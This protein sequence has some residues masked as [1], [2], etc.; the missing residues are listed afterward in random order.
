MHLSTDAS[1]ELWTRSC[2]PGCRGEAET[3]RNDMAV[4]GDRLS[5]P[6]P[7]LLRVRGCGPGWSRLSGL[8]VS[9]CDGARVS[10]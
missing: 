10:W 1:G 2:H 8:F 5:Q 4:G 9:F 7:G 3:S 6:V